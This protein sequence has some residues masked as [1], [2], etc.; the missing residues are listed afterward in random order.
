MRRLGQKHVEARRR[1]GRRRYVL[2]A[3]D[4]LQC[5]ELVTFSTLSQI[6]RPERGQRAVRGSLA[7]AT[8]VDLYSELHVEQLASCVVGAFTQK[9]AATLFHCVE[10]AAAVQLRAHMVRSTPRATFSAWQTRPQTRSFSPA[11]AI[12]LAIVR[13]SAGRR[14]LAVFSIDRTLVPGFTPIPPYAPQTRRLAVR[15]GP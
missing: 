10:L 3:V 1:D 11:S 9:P 5:G 8:L 2:L 4:R 6:L 12:G 14:I 13:V 7:R 15:K